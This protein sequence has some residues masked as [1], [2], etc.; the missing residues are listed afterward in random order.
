MG[1]RTI[2]YDKIAKS[3]VQ[4]M[5]LSEET[6]QCG[7]G[8]LVYQRYTFEFVFVSYAGGTKKLR[9]T[10]I[11]KGFYTRKRGRRLTLSSFPS[12]F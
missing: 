6:V 7:V 2:R 12:I 8:I 9:R 5:G 3:N 1:T 10:H 11:I 4:D